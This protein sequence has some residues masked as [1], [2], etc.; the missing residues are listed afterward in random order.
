MAGRSSSAG[1]R[2]SPDTIELQEGLDALFGEHDMKTLRTVGDMADLVHSRPGRNGS[3]PGVRLGDRRKETTMFVWYKRS[4]ERSRARVLW[5]PLV[6]SLV[7]SVVL[8]ILL[9]AVI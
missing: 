3:P 6:L 8:T 7:V 9:N 5:W 1:P 2:R 4:G